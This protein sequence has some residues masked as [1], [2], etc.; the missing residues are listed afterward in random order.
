[1]NLSHHPAGIFWSHGNPELRKLSIFYLI[2][3]CDKVDVENE[4]NMVNILFFEV[5]ATNIQPHILGNGSPETAFCIL[6]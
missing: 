6:S 5:K 1:M 2:C 4:G 3:I